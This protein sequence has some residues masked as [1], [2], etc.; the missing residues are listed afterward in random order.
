MT[1]SSVELL[2]VSQK[3][4]RGSKPDGS[5]QYRMVKFSITG[6]KGVSRSVSSDKKEE[7]KSY[8]LCA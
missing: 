7:E 1:I 4:F 6:V 2:Q 8:L 5:T 3:N